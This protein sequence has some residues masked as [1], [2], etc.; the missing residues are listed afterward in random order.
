MAIKHMESTSPLSQKIA[1]RNTDVILVMVLQLQLANLCVMLGKI[2]NATNLHK[3][4]RNIM[5]L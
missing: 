3:G 5:H 4:S 1:R 2:P